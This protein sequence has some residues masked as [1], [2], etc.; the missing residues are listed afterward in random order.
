[1]GKTKRIHRT[2]Q[3]RKKLVVIGDGECGKTCL[4]YVFSQDK[5]PDGYIP[6]V[7]ETYVA[8]I[9]IDGVQV[10]LALWDTA[11]QDDYD[12]L[13]PLSYPDTDVLLLCFSVENPD[14][15][16]NASMKWYPEAKHYCP[17][18]PVVLVGTKTDLRT[19]EVLIDRATNQKYKHVTTEEG[20]RLAEK[21]KATAYIECSAKTREGIREVFNTATA[22]ALQKRRTDHRRC[23]IL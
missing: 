16:E 14:S 15:F 19:D 1:M 13:R 7:F 11:G 3:V 2:D 20:R 23:K 18:V 12:R 5:F 17:N 6:T 9:H 4:L 10:E 22:A 21:I 8:D